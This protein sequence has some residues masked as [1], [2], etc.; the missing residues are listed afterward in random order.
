MKGGF[1]EADRAVRN[2]P[3]PNDSW[4]WRF[5]IVKA[6]ALLRQRLNQQSLE[7]LEPEPPGSFA[8][9]DIVVWRKLTQGSAYCYLSEFP[10]SEQRFAEAQALASRY[11]PELLGEVA[12]RKGTLAFWRDDAAE[13]ASAYRNALQIA[14]AQNDKYLEAAALGSLGVAATRQAHYDESIDWNRQA[15]ELSRAEGAQVSVTKIL[16]NTGWSYFEIGDYDKALALFQQAEDA[17][18]KEGLLGSAL[19]WRINIGAV[20]LYLHDYAGAEQDS[21]QALD[22]AHRLG[23]KETIVEC[24]NALSDIYLA[25]GG[26]DSAEDYNKEALE[27]TRTS[28]DRLGEL[29]STL[30]Q[31]RIE[32]SRGNHDR[33]EQLLNEVIRDPGAIASL[34]W[35]ARARLAV[36][37]ENSGRAADASRE[38][39]SSIDEVEG[40]QSSIQAEELRVSFLSR[41]IDFYDDYVDFLTSEHRNE[42]ALSVADYSRARTLVEG[43]GLENARRGVSGTFVKWSEVARRENTIVLAYWL[44]FRHSYLWAITPSGRVRQFELSPKEEIDPL[45]QSYVSALMGPRDVLATDNE[46]GKRLFDLLVAP[47]KELLP[48]GA[49]VVVVPDGSLW[50]LN[51]EALLVAAPS[52]HYWI[53]DVVIADTNSLAL[54]AAA[55]R[56]KPAS[57]RSL[58]LIGNPT[59]EAAEFPSLAQAPVEMQQI[60]GYFPPRDRK[61]FSGDNATPQAYLES[62]PGKFSFIHFTAHGTSSRTTPLDSAIILAGPGGA[63]KL[64]GRDVVKIPL[65]ASL[66]TISAC[67]GAGSRNYS[68]EGLVGLSW[69]FLRAGAHGVIAALWEANDSSTTEIMNSLYGE[70]SHGKDPAVALRDAKLALLHSGTIYQK[71]FYWASFQYYI[72]S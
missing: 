61:V 24:L 4:H 14:R 18:N 71:P 9:S 11:H 41:A 29:S 58:L 33:A 53:D 5:T 38:F 3:D 27:L 60:E 68:G 69:A 67:H 12:L 54:L 25:K 43:L 64:Y 6:E 42:E 1:D 62:D 7:L 65:H 36:V 13:A 19:D 46:A 32:S 51:F 56:A 20:R 22:L 37:Y 63:F 34:R 49:R 40:A 50:G 59:S 28:H 10:E 21:R 44:G 26:I 52:L 16:G 39:R 23:N 31:G 45:V 47:A 66:V 70:V 57:R 55:S 72:G 30:I 15:L 17:S 48:K 2:F 35:E 8:A